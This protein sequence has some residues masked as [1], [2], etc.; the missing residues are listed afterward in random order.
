MDMSG[1]TG[2]HRQRLVRGIPSGSQ[3]ALQHGWGCCLLLSAI[4]LITSL[5]FVVS[6]AVYGTIAF[7]NFLAI[8]GVI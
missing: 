6:R 7:H 4:G 1:L 5:F 2:D 3:P 8:F